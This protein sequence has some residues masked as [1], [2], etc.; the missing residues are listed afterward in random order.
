M[1]NEGLCRGR[2]NLDP[3]K[4]T[5]VCV[6]LWALSTAFYLCGGLK[7]RFWGFFCSFIY[8]TLFWGRMG[9]MD[10]V[11]FLYSWEAMLPTT[12]VKG[13]GFPSVFDTVVQH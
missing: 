6:F 1:L 7:V 8:F 11:S 4:S 10:P 12:L 2:G 13:A 3:K 5:S 9:E